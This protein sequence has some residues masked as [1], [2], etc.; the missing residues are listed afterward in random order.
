MVIKVAICDDVP[1]ISKEIEELL[2]EYD[3]S[4]FEIDIFYNPFRLIEKLKENKYDMFIL[5]MEFPN[6]SGLEIAE[7][8]RRNNYTSPIIFVTSFKEYMEKA[9]KVNTFDYILKPITKSKLHSALNRAIKYLDLNESN[10]TFTFNKVF[11][12]LP[13]S[14]II[15][16]EKYKRKVFIHTPS[17]TYETILHTKAL[18][19]KVND[20]YLQVHTSFVINVR[21]IKEI[22]NNTVTMKVS[23][24]QTVD[25]P[26]SRKF[27]DHAKKQILMKLRNFIN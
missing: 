6:L 12:S 15:Y 13:F 21:Y 2:L 11:Y 3:S 16:F 14:N 26:I 27:K 4:L 8:I 18:L 25:I 7:D 5:D 9:F 22:R 20:N 17:D 23:N 10:F 1:V 19:S 24:K